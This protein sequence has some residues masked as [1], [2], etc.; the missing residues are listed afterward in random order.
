MKKVCI[1]YNTEKEIAQEMYRESVEYFQKRNIEILDNNRGKISYIYMGHK[2]DIYIPYI[3]R[4]AIK[5][6]DFK[7][8]LI[9]NDSII[10]ITQQPGIPYLVNAKQLDGNSIKLTNLSTGATH[11]YD[12]TECPLY[13]TEI[14]E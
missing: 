5:M 9:T 7:A 6:T 2:Y 4:N 3:R 14:M 12:L 13:G 8:E 11:T 1:I 10:N